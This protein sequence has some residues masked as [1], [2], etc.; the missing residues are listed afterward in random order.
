M[1]M[2]KQKN[3]F[4]KEDFGNDYP[5]TCVPGK[6]MEQTLPEVLLRHM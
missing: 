2:D 4:R 3:S 1:A 6:I 5:V